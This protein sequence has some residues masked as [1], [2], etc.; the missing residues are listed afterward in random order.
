M[1]EQEHT[2]RRAPHMER[3]T[4][5]IPVIMQDYPD[6]QNVFLAV[7]NQSFCVSSYGCETK[8]EAEW[9]R[10]MLCI[11]L[12]QLVREASAVNNN[13]TGASSAEEAVVPK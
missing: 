6:A 11:A 3:F 1:G 4:K 9:M 2:T 5:I 10:D 7:G 12:D 13:L 8:E